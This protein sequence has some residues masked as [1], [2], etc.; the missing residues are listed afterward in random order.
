MKVEIKNSTGGV[1]IQGEYE[2]IRAAVECAVDHGVNLSDADLTITNLSDADLSDA[3]LSGA[4][5][6]H[7]DL[8]YSDLNGAN[9][10]GARL[11]GA[12]LSHASL[13]YA[14]LTGANLGDANLNGADLTDANLAYADLSGTDLTNANLSRASLTNANLSRAKLTNAN[15]ID[16]DLAYASLSRANLNGVVADLRLVLECAPAEVGELLA[17]LRRGGVDG[18]FY[19]GECACLVGTLAN[20]RGVR[21]DAFPGLRPNSARPA[22]VW[23]LAIREG[24]TPGTSPIVKLTCEWIEA[25]MNEKGN[26]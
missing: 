22:E 6:G 25:W 26:P 24:D 14:D 17:V 20:V 18:R 7:A 23:A 13:A 3:H 1:I 5:L 9:L 12:N 2:S 21:F 19:E 8:S 4:H 11:Y 16:A 15:V 10:R